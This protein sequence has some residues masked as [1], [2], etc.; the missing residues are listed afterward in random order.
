MSSDTSLT[1]KRGALTSEPPV[2]SRADCG[3]PQHGSLHVLLRGCIHKIEQ[4]LF[5]APL[6]A[7]MASD[8]ESKALFED[9]SLSA[10]PELLLGNLF[11]LLSHEGRKG[12]VM[13]FLTKMLQL[14]RTE[15]FGSARDAGFEKVGLGSE[16]Y[17]ELFWV[18]THTI[19]WVFER[20]TEPPPMP[21]PFA[22]NPI[23]WR[24]AQTPM[25]VQQLPAQ[26]NG[27][28][29]IL[30][31]PDSHFFFEDRPLVSSNS[32]TTAAPVPRPHR[33]IDHKSEA[34]AIT[35]QMVENERILR[36]TL[37]P[38]APEL[39]DP[40]WYP[41]HDDRAPRLRGDGTAKRAVERQKP[42]G[43][44]ELPEHNGRAP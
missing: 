39:R 40:R 7:I 24:P 16:D 3:L 10:D 9:L 43:H 26:I 34:A 41:N 23:G 14:A 27:C 15:A 33:P 4:V 21:A 11:K 36:A 29:G 25:L 37:P 2:H 5:C 35:A 32:N 1:A 20:A 44:G 38:G 18:P 17:W 22:A 28:H 8:A 13:F 30:R 12:D 19:D 31:A 42:H 6:K